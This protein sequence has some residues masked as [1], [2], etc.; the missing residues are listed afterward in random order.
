[1]GI[2]LE[3]FRNSLPVVDVG[4]AQ[5]GVSNRRCGGHRKF[6]PVTDAR[7][8]LCQ[9]IAEILGKPHRPRGILSLFLGRLRFLAVGPL[10]PI[11]V[12][13]SISPTPFFP[14]FL[15]LFE[16]LFGSFLEATGRLCLSQSLPLS[17][18]LSLSLSL[19]SS[20]ALCRLSGILPD[21]NCLF[22]NRTQVPD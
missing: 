12:P 6:L 10:C 22:A 1:M 15:S 17:L 5:F 4:R 21:D 9:G 8:E 3:F 20:V 14:A 18:S 16:L 11:A 19:L 2:L 13:F 7:F